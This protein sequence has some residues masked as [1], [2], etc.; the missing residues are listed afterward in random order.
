L[1]FRPGST[2]VDAL[3]TFNSTDRVNAANAQNELFQTLNK[4]SDG[5]F[6]GELQLSD[7]PNA[8]G[9]ILSLTGMAS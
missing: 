5:V 8:D 1:N 3:L 6:L 4:T 9:S 7:N 2:V